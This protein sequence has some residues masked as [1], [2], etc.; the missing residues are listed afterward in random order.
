MSNPV[1]ENSPYFGERRGTTP[2]GYPTHPGYAPSA[3]TTYPPAADPQQVQ[4][5]EYAYQQPAAGPAQTGRLT[6]DDVIVKTGGLLALVVAMGA[7]N[8]FVL[9]GNMIATFG[10]LAVGLVLGLVNA[11]KREP[12]P[13]LIAVYAAA[14]GLFLGGISMV[15][16]SIYP[17][18]VLQAVLATGAT[19]VAT[20]ALYSSGKIRVTPKMT[21]FVLIAL[22]GYALFSLVNL[23]IM[24][25]GSGDS[26]FGL[27]S[28][29]EIMGIPLGVIIGVFAVGLAAFCL[30]L[31]FDAI[32]RGVQA[33]IPSR[34][35]WSAAFGLLVTLVWLYLE[36]LRLLAILRG[37][38]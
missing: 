25:L 6:Y 34:Y 26:A 15:F 23:G 33:G 38:D 8:W 30:I 9:G 27:R 3:G 31:D 19:F 5:L 7:L 28:S 1:F 17:G 35:A 14:E 11:F 18:I 32:K 4:N 20:L 16:E 22:V 12:S 2:S 37:G 21:R 36:F 29:V 13:A 24:L 10:G